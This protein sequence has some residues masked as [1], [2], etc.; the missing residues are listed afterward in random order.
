MF[1]ANLRRTKTSKSKKIRPE[2]ASDHTGKEYGELIK[3]IT[4]K[5]N[6]F[7]YWKRSTVRVRSRKHKVTLEISLEILKRAAN[8]KAPGRDL[9]VM[10]WIKKLTSCHHHLVNIME[11]LLTGQTQVPQWLSLSN[12]NLLPKN[13]DTHKPENYRPVALQNNLY[14]VYTSILNHF[15]ADHCRENNIISIEQAAGK[16]GSC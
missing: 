1:T 11:S 8:N 2:K 14:K 9:I 16:N 6:G 15:L 7:H 3:N 5:Q 13:T 4:H 12:T 10:Y